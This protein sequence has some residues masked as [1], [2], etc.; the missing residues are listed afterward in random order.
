M[1]IG[2]EKIVKIVSKTATQSAIRFCSIEKMYKIKDGS[3]PK[4]HQENTTKKVDSINLLPGLFIKRWKTKLDYIPSA[5]S[6]DA[7]IS[8]FSSSSPWGHWITLSHLIFM[9]LMGSH[10]KGSLKKTQWKF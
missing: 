7:G 2:V 10:N 3:V 1:R 6:S 4:N 9:V 5:N 8:Q